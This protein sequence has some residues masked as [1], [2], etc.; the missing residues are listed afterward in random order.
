[1]LLK[2]LREYVRS[3][4]L[5]MSQEDVETSNDPLDWIT[6]AYNDPNA[7]DA[8][9]EFDAMVIAAKKINL[10]RV[11]NPGSSRIVFDLKN[12]R[13]VKLARNNKGLAQNNL[14]AFAGNDPQV[15]RILATVWDYAEDFSWVV[16]D[17]VEPLGD[18]DGAI[19]EEIVGISWNEVRELVGADT[20]EEYEATAVGSDSNSVKKGNKKS[21]GKGS[22][23]LSGDAFLSYIDDFMTRYSDM[24]PG[25]IAKLSSWG[26]TPRGCLVLL[27][28]GI[29][30]KKFKELYR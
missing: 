15:E 30:R 8:T 10:Q 20:G 27:D 1:M 21:S 2:I 6:A 23:C 26:V 12:N 22:G 11:G 5:E 13:V 19:A 29:T 25:D 4:I 18:D 17:K 7:W 28:Y 9:D 14:E 16:A 24:L 3:Q